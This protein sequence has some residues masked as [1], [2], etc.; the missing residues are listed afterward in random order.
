[1]SCSQQPLSSTLGCNLNVNSTSIP[2]NNITTVILRPLNG[3]TIPRADI[4]EGKAW[5]LTTLDIRKK[6]KADAKRY[7][8]LKVHRWFINK[9]KKRRERKKLLKEID[10]NNEDNLTIKS[11]DISL[12]DFFNNKKVFANELE[13]WFRSDIFTKEQLDSIFDPLNEIFVDKIKECLPVSA[14]KATESTVTNLHYVTLSNGQKWRLETFDSIYYEI[15]SY[16]QTIQFKNLFDY[17]TELSYDSEAVHFNYKLNFDKLNENEDSF[18][19]CIGF[20]NK[21]FEII[22]GNIDFNTINIEDFL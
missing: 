6:W 21:Q 13:E 12:I 10:S 22:S 20:S 7:I 14:G 4:F 11:G 8:V 1:M 3:T 2:I 15:K 17:N 18:N 16:S 9:M 5:A 19:Q